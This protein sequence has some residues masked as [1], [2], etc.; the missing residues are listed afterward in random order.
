MKVLYIGHYKEG[1][2]WSKASINSIHALNRSGADVVCRNIQLTKPN[3]IKIDPL[4]LELES[5][6][7]DNID[8]C[9]QNV[10]PHH[11]VGTQKFKKNIGYFVAE[12]NT[13]KYNS[14]T[15][16]LGLMD[17]VWVPNNELKTNME[18]DGFD[19]NRV[20]VIP[21][22]FN[23]DK[24]K[25]NNVLKIDF[26]EN[27][28]KFKFYYIGDYN[29]RKNLESII[30][31]FHSEFGPNEPV[32]LIIKVNKF[33]ISPEDLRSHIKRLCST[34]KE[35]LRIYKDIREYHEELI[36]TQNITDEQIDSL[37]LSCDCLVCP[38]HGEGWSIPAFDAMAFGKTPICSN[39][40][41]PKEFIDPS[42]KNTGYLV[43][44]VYDI[45][46]HADPAFPE[47]FTG[48]EEWFHPSESEIKKA[49]RFYYENKIK[50]TD[51]LIMAENFSY[52]KVG[53]IIKEAIHA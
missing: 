11:M 31:C 28:Y 52:D 41:G 25:Q 39:E 48:R 17:E 13:T 33:G 53:Q 6:P 18:K 44:G 43:D 14:W 35:E 30:R 9:I 27:Q 29:D 51:G 45:C 5:K 34:V 49:M 22:A 32:C 3:N 4:I 21:Y 40:G 42:N 15:Q 16:H 10:L 19:P 46:N 23:I 20:R 1:T 2:G 50:S 47:L 8:I 37:H 7:L 26:A 12:S 24:Y 36:L 38:T